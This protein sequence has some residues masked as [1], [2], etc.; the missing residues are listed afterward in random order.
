MSNVLIEA[1]SLCGSETHV[2]RVNLLSASSVE[3]HVLDKSDRT[4][5]LY[6]HTFIHDAHV[7]LSQ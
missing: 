6:I 7:V 4:F 3:T 5:Y 1:M 2:S